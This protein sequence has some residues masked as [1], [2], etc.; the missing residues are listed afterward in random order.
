MIDWVF[1]IVRFEIRLRDAGIK[2][3]MNKTQTITYQLK[4]N[5]A[6]DCLDYFFPLFVAPPT[7]KNHKRIKA[8]E[9]CLYLFHINSTRSLYYTCVRTP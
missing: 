9:A 2:F 8:C 3:E 6:H 7:P 5:R 1:N 4:Q